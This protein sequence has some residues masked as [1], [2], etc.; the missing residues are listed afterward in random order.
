VGRR[1][2]GRKSEKGQGPA[3]PEGF[4][5]VVF[6]GQCLMKADLGLG[7][8]LHKAGSTNWT[9]PQ[10]WIELPIR[11]PIIAGVGLALR[12]RICEHGC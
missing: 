7:G 8:C 12:S 2:A 6:A 11:Q 1:E 5:V 3:A 9:C 4:L 10:G